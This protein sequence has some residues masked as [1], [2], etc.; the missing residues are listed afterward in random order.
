MIEYVQGIEYVH[1]KGGY[2]QGNKYVHERVGTYIVREAIINLKEIQ[3]KNLARF[4]FK[5]N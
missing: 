2:V 3:R 1:K 4:I 5:S